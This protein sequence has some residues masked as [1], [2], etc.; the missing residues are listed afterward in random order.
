MQQLCRITEVINWIS[1]VVIICGKVFVMGIRLKIL[2]AFILCYGLMGSVSL[3]LLQRSMNESYDAIERSDIAANMGRVQQSFEASAASLK[4]QTKDWAIWN[5]MYRYALNPNPEWV[6]ENIGNDALAPADISMAMVFA[7]DGRLLTISAVNINGTE[8]KI[9]TPQITSYL[10]QIK[11]GAQQAQCGIIKIDAGLMLVCWASIVQSDASGDPVG[12]VLMGRLLDSVRLLKLREQT[13][14]SFELSVQDQVPEGLVQW[15]GMLTPGAIGNGEFWT[16]S[17]TD[18]YHLFYPVQDILKQNVGLI[19]LNVPRSVHQ[20]GLMLYQQVRQ[21][22]GWT[23]LIMTALLGLA[24]HFILIRRLRR[25]A[26]QIDFLEEHSTWKTRID[27][28]GDDEL[29]LVASNFNKLL[30]LIRTQDRKSV[31]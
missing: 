18:V 22:L 9:L 20:Q 28:G 29:A 11:T 31:V 16:S 25:F 7:K 2:L 14:L 13:K 6:K 21:Q 17:D 10:D 27:I 8:L 24:L 4:N 15:T 26:R 30:V 12:T 5:E 1:Y 23:V 3:S 19:S